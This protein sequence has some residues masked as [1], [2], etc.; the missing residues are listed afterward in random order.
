MSIAGY[1]CLAALVGAILVGDM[2][3]VLFFAACCLLDCFHNQGV[4]K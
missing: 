1:I 3:A 4:F 2:L